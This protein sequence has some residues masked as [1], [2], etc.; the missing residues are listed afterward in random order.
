MWKKL[1]DEAIRVQ[2]GITVSP[3]I[4]A[5]SV[6]AAILTNKAISMLVFV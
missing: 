4:E 2:N 1:Y 6:A 5:S 3:F